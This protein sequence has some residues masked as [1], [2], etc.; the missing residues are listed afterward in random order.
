MASYLQRSGAVW[1]IEP[2]T[3]TLPDHATVIPLYDENDFIYEVLHSIKRA[4]NH[5][6]EPVAIIL[7]INEPLNAPAESIQNNR[8]L[9]QSLRANDGKFDGGLA[10]GRELF[11]IDLTDKELPDKHRTVGN[12]RKSGFDSFLA[13]SDGKV[14]DKKRLLFSLDADTL[15]SENY[16][17]SSFEWFT[18]HPKTGGAVIPFEH[19]TDGFSAEQKNAV[20]RYEYYLWDYALKLRNC[21]SR[22]GYWCIGS[23]FF[24]NGADYMACG[25]MRRNAAGE[26]FY[27]LQALTKVAPLGIVPDCQV[28]P[29]GRISHRVPFGTGPAVAR[30]LAGE[31]QK[32]FND[33]IFALLKEF[34]TAVNQSDFD[35]LSQDITPLAPAELQEF[36]RTVDF[37]VV[38]AKI[39]SN[40]PRNAE[41]LRKN[42]HN[43]CDGFF[44][45]K[46]AHFLEEKYPLCFPRV[47]LP[48]DDELPSGVQELRSQ[49]I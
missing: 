13:Q 34:F 4:L 2:L 37:S 38:W 16:F 44:I 10:V 26:D 15:V 6:P 41:A 43:F 11:F 8:E 31:E 29:A 12:A 46:F 45:L 49:F 25:G 1:Q 22:Y 7:V 28:F 5:S 3:A 19:R 36:F 48:A 47:P 39:V 23:A 35:I 17:E 20:L 33:G 42:L 40:S 21:G 14:T 27:F 18:R 24:C 32:L 9:L 30:Q